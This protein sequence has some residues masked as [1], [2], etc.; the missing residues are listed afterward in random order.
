MNKNQKHR[1]LKIVELYAQS[2]YNGETSDAKHEA[3][4][5]YFQNI[6]SQLGMD[7]DEIYSNYLAEQYIKE[8][9]SLTKG[10]HGN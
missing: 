1:F 7:F 4:V 3:A 9:E 2:R 10:E 6:A 5:P 8:A